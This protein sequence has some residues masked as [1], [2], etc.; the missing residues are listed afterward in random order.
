MNSFLCAW[1]TTDKLT[2]LRY[3]KVKKYFGNLKTAWEKADRQNL[4]QAGLEAK[5]AE[6]LARLKETVKK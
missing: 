4:I 3:Q 2:F 1:A 6:K 5:I